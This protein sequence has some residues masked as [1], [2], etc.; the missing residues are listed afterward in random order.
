MYYIY[1]YQRHGDKL[2]LKNWMSAELYIMVK[3]A[4]A[5]NKIRNKYEIVVDTDG[6][7]L[8]QEVLEEK[9]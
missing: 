7:H 1:F 2:I 8:L 6:S 9:Q 5:M 3:I 4:Y